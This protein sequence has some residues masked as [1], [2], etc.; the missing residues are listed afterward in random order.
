MG[1]SSQWVFQVS[2]EKVNTAGYTEQ[3]LEAAKG[4]HQPSSVLSK[5][6][7]PSINTVSI[8]YV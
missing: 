1:H 2:G 8:I 7:A 6:T 3:C 4:K 5:V